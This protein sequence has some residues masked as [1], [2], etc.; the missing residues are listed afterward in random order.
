[1][2]F[3]IKKFRFRVKS[4]FKEWKGADWGHSLNRDFTVFIITNFG[5][6]VFPGLTEKMFCPKPSGKSENLCIL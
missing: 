6:N 3:R 2:E 4:R 5:F 1:M